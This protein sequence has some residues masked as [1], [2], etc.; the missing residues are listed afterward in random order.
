MTLRWYARRWP[1]LVPWP[2]LVIGRIRLTALDGTRLGDEGLVI[3]VSWLCFDVA[4]EIR[5]EEE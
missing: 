5:R 2:A 1:A 4:V 3:R